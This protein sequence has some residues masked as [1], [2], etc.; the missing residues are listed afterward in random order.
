M[1]LSALPIENLVAA[2]AP[3]LGPQG[4][5]TEA[6]GIERYTVDF[7]HQHKGTT[8]LVLRPDS[9]EA[10]AAIVRE[11]ARLGVAIVPQSGNSGLVAGGIP[12]GSGRQVVLSLERL[13][14]IRAVDAAGGSLVAEAGCILADVQAAADGA[15]RLFPLSLGA[16]GSC[17]IGG[18]L[19]TN[20]GGVNVLRYGMT[21]QLVLGLEVVL[22]DGRVWNGLRAL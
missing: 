14:R 1:T 4:I 6:A 2:L 13:N 18:N 21:R 8:P 19:S 12:D 9:T 7:W 17:R 20:A 16:E 22:A 15:G 5:I 10:V 11:A 3:L